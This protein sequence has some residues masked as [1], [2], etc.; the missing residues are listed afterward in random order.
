M[1]VKDPQT[2]ELEFWDYTAR[3]IDRYSKTPTQYNNGPFGSEKDHFGYK[4]DS[5]VGA[6]NLFKGVVATLARG[7]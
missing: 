5:D 7:S 1:S 3:V 6:L 4:V 2:T